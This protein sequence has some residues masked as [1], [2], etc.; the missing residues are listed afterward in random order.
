MKSDR[1]YLNHILN[2]IKRV[3]NATC[4]G[5]SSFLASQLHQDAILRN[6]HTMTETTQR[7]SDG[8]KSEHPEVDWAKLAA[9][10]NVLVH[11]Y[12]GIDLELVWTVVTRDVPAFKAEVTKIL[13]SIE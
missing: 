13:G 9:F 5:K 1:V 6:L 11:D 4:E 8:L 2:M 7:L 12:L 10:R 3:E